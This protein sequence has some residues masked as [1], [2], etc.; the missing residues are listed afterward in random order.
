MSRQTLADWLTEAIELVSNEKDGGCRGIELFHKL[1]GADISLR[2]IPV[3]GSRA[4]ECKQLANLLLGVMKNHALGM[5]GV[6]N[7]EI[8]AYKEGESEPY[9]RRPEIANGKVDFDGAGVEAPTTTGHA[10]QMMRQNEALF[11]ASMSHN[12]EVFDRL[13]TVIELQGKQN[14]KLMRENHDALELAKVMIL[15]KSNSEYAQ[16]IELKKMDR[17][18]KER[19]QFIQMLPPLFNKLTGT[20]TFPESSEDTVLVNAIA[21]NITP[22]QIQALAAMGINPMLLGMLAARLEKRVKE[23]NQQA[24]AVV[25][26]QGGGNG[27]SS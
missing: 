1:P 6:Q 8:V 7:Y 12:E 5:V 3:G 19:E 23:K 17:A 14:E 26:K 9:A 24:L 21:D 16:A 13:L 18:N 20:Q 25:E 22:E 4:T 27:T 15:D 10:Q 2:Q 11:R